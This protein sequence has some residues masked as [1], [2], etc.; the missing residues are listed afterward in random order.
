MGTPVS[1]VE[2][3]FLWDEQ[4]RCDSNSIPVAAGEQVDRVPT[5]LKASKFGGM[6]F[7]ER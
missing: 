1:G 6:I 4:I 2:S 7:F 3:R 5:G